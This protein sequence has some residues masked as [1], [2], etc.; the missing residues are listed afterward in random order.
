MF[1]AMAL[2]AD[3][4]QI[5]SRFILTPESSAHNNFKETIVGLNE[6]DTMLT[7]KELTPVRLVKNEFFKKVEAAYENCATNDEL[8]TLLGRGRAK[9]GMFEGDLVE[10]EL[11]VGQISGLIGEIKSAAEIV[12]EIIHDFNQKRAEMQNEIYSFQ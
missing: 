11:E 4:V 6:G 7:L 3:A 12:E 10:G 8:N 1:A 5:G 2:G 9:K